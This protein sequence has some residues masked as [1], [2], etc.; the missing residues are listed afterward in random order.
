MKKIFFFLP[1]VLVVLLSFA[2]A[3]NHKTSNFVKGE[4]IVKLKENNNADVLGV[5]KEKVRKIIPTNKKLDMGLDRLYL[6]KVNDVKSAIRSLEKNPGIEYA[7]PNY[8]VKIAVIPNDPY[9]SNLYGLHN[10]GQT[11][12]TVD[13]D[14][15]A[16]ESWDTQ[17][18]SSNVVVAVIDTGVDYNHEDLSTNMWTN[19]NEIPNN[20]IDDDNNTFVDD[21]LGWDFINNDNNPIDDHGHGTHV[22]GTIG[23]VANNGIGVAGVSWN[24]KIMPLKFLGADGFGTTANAVSAVQYAT[25]MNVHI[26][27]NSWGGGDYS[28]ALRD[29]IEAANQAGIL[30]VAASGNSGVNTDVTPNYPS[31]YDNENIVAVAATDH[32]DTLVYFSNY[33]AVSVDLAAPGVSILSTVPQGLCS[34]CDA[35]G[36]KSLSGTS[37]ATPH[38]S[39][40]AALIKAQYGATHLQIKTR[41]LRGVD[42]IVSLQDK[43]VSEGR[44]NVFSSLENDSIAP[45]AITDLTAV[46]KSF[47]S[48]TLNWTA[49][50]E[51]GSSGTASAYEL[52][53]STSSISDANW[54][55]A[56][57]ATNLPKPKSPDSSESFKV[58]GLSSSTTYYFAI[59]AIDNVGNAGTISNI[60]TETTTSSAVFFYDDFESDVGWTAN[61]LWH[62]ENSKYYSL[63]T[64]WTYN[65]GAPTYDYDTGTSNSGALTSPSIDLTSKSSASLR[66]QDYYETEASTDWDQRWVQVSLN[67]GPFTNLA[68]L[69]GEPMNSWHQHEI[70]LA[71]YA[72][73]VI[74]FRFF[75]D[76][77]DSFYN[78][79]W[80]WSIDD[81]TILTDAASINNPPVANAGPDQIV[82][83][84]DGSGNETVTLN[85]SASYDPDGTIIGYEWKEGTTLLGTSS[86]ITTSLP[87][88]THSIQLKVT[89]NLG[90]SGSD[91]VSV[92]VTDKVT[93]T[94]A[95]YKASNKEILVEAVSTKPDAVLTLLGYGQMTKQLSKW[96]YRKK[97]V[98]DPGQTVTVT[99]S[100]GGSATANVKHI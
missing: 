59:K 15:D 30:F 79:Y 1:F 8:I 14:I 61:G 83:D 68:Q 17:T 48:I 12:G 91:F 54:D 2:Y 57:K 67:N 31:A 5:E 3:S 94:R 13:A 25:T 63:S 96:V 80:G 37:M 71:S 53:Y 66:F 10:I 55:T 49:T 77:I 39:G 23:A 97:N 65:K 24:V 72:G 38:V 16:P 56:V 43:I 47:N 58:S 20:G 60:A 89:D 4:V 28:Q 90:V 27:S 76:S 26:M 70:D 82:A 32:N 100:Y 19:T 29:A 46:D 81:F 69:Y 75:F 40:A 44:L 74:Q 42:S 86:I 85:G 88:G 84:S 51:D 99:S 6:V 92:A 93:I 22:S 21:Y 33:G 11:G 95:Q 73:N 45:A 64:S 35:S 87:V 50:G 7:E 62:L 36:Y 9:F 18:G 78:N 41:L 34:F 98:A 52:R